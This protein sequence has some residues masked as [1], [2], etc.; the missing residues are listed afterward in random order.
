M[1]WAWVGSHGSEIVPK[2][3]PIAYH[4][5]RYAANV[6]TDEAR[7]VVNL[8]LITVCASRSSQALGTFLA[9]VMFQCS[10]Q[11]V[12][13]CKSSSISYLR[14]TDCFYGQFSLL[15]LLLALKGLYLCPYWP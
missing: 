3:E 15:L 12:D 14:Q 2:N 4:G 1:I 5:E 9:M 6:D 13:V 7:M 8:L 10:L 11:L